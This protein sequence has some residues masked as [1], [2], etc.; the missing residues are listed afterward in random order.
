VSHEGSW[1][2][3]VDT[4]QLGIIMPGRPRVRMKFQA[5]NVP[6]ITMENDKVVSLSKTV[7]VPAGRFRNC[8][9]IQEDLSDGTTEYKYYAPGVGVVKESTPDGDLDLISHNNSGHDEDERD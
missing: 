7:R 5:E 9:Q 6:G 1:L 8:A 4:D 2:F 3:G